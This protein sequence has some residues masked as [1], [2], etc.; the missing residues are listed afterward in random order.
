MSIFSTVQSWNR[1]RRT[2]NTLNGLSSYQ[3]EDI[4]V[5]RDAIAGISKTTR[6]L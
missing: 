5:S 4:G 2:R 6:G 1:A 3:L